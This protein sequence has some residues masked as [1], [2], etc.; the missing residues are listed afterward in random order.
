MIRIS[1]LILFPHKST[2]LEYCMCLLAFQEYKHP[3]IIISDCKIGTSA[4]YPDLMVS[5][6]V[7]TTT[8]YYMLQWYLL[9]VTG[10]IVTVSTL[11]LEVIRG[12]SSHLSLRKTTHGGK[13]V[14]W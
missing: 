8:P 9:L 7:Q 4:Q 1:Q 6:A 14:W 2:L 12:G 5:L 10:I 13:H 11:I 3:M